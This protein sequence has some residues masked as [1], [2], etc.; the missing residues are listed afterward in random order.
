MN[1]LCLILILLGPTAAAW[2][3]EKSNKADSPA[4]RGYRLLY[5]GPFADYD[6]R[7]II[8][9]SKRCLG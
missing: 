3:E 4:Q 9:Y 8:D 7:H 5:H 1:R 6:L 2:A